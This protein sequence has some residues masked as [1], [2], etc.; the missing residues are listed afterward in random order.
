M[1]GVL[2]ILSRVTSW[3]EGMLENAGDQAE[4]ALPLKS[5]RARRKTNDL[6]PLT[7]HL[8]A[9]PLHYRPPPNLQ[10]RRHQPVGQRER[11]HQYMPAHPLGH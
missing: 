5:T 10:R 7:A 2:F 4:I 9:K 1:Q 3:G 11:L 6:D 8:A